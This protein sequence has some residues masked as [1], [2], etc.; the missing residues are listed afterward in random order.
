MYRFHV[1]SKGLSKQGRSAWSEAILMI[2]IPSAIRL[3]VIS[4]AQKVVCVQAP[5]CSSSAMAATMRTCMSASASPYQRPW[6][7]GCAIVGTGA[8]V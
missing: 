3:S 4:C 2:L 7:A 8:G 6:A 5:A 1:C